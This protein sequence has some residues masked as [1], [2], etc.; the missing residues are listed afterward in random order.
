MTDPNSVL[1]KLLWTP[2]GSHSEIDS[3]ASFVKSEKGFDWAGDYHKLWQWSV[4]EK[5]VFWSSLWDWHDV[6][7]EKGTRLL[8]NK[9]Q[10][11]GA[12]FFPDASVN[13]AQNM[14]AEADDRPAIIAYGEDGRCTRLTRA[15]LKTTVMALAGWMQSKGSA[16]VTALL[17]TCQMGTCADSDASNGSN[18]RH[19]SSCSPDLA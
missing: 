17:P 7:G 2:D 18:W 6:I 5:D 3:Y 12:R 15:E 10:M 14:L 16:K 4:Q 9:N 19:F 8:I 1:G 11:P 13:Y